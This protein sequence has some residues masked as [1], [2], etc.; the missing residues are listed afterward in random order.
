MRCDLIEATLACNMDGIFASE[1]LPT[2][3]GHVNE[4][5]LEFDSANPRRPTRSAA[6]R[7]ML[8]PQDV[9]ST[10]SPRLVQSLIASASKRDW[11]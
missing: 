8:K 3:D 1:R 7:V 6:R 10:M 5:W 2:T 4:A 11:V 9:S